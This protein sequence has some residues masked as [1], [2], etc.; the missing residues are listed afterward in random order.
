M[1]FGNMGGTLNCIIVLIIFLIHPDPPSV[2]INR[3]ESLPGLRSK[4]QTTQSKDRQGRLTYKIGVREEQNARFRMRV[5][6]MTNG[7]Q[8][9]LIPVSTN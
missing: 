3:T 6:N 7:R 2:G 8:H 1:I 4:R 5:L 9:P